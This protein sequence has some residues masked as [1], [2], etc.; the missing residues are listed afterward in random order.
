[1]DVDAVMNAENDVLIDMGLTKI[2]D[3]LSL[4]GYCKTCG[5]SDKP[6]DSTN[7]KRALLQAVLSSSKKGKK[8][9][10]TKKNSNQSSLSVAKR[11]KKTKKVQ[12]GWKHFNEEEL[13][14]VQ[15]PLR[16]GGGSREIE[17]QMSS[18]KL[19]LLKTSKSLFFPNGMSTYG[20]EEQ[21]TFDL[22]NFK[23]EKIETTIGVDRKVLPFNLTNY[24]A[25]HKMKNIR[26]YLQSQ[27]LYDDSS[28]GE[29]E[30]DPLPMIYTNDTDKNTSLIGSTDDRQALLEEQDKAYQESLNADK[31]KVKDLERN[32]SEDERKQRIHQA[33]V[34]RV[35][36]EP[37]INYVTIKVRHVTMGL[38]SRRFS[39][40]CN[41]VAVYDWAGALSPDI[42]NF[43]LCD[44]FGLVLLPGSQLVDRST[45]SMVEV[46]HT[47]S[48][49]ETDSDIQFLGFGDTSTSSEG[50]VQDLEK[51]KEVHDENFNLEA[52]TSQ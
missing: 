2:G 37:D 11:E 5:H 21:M 48:L 19:D 9:D 52:G 45:V 47:P 3:R 18:N 29:D 7:K 50:A 8:P 25:A 14:Y 31:Q 51:N 17:M 28:D 10:N 6:D 42:E 32:A 46:F 4:R 44:P 49:S 43:T 27:K 22:S 41:M 38:C 15:V 35:A 39:L 1:M 23:D 33:R 24:L 34:A 12:L 16:K 36:P 13:K 30:E 26:I 40:D 20:K